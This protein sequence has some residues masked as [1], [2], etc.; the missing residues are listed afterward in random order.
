[1]KTA[2]RSGRSKGK[3][4]LTEAERIEIYERQKGVCASCGKEFAIEDMG[5]DHITPLSEGGSTSMDNCQMLC[6]ECNQKK[7]SGEGKVMVSFR[8]DSDIKEKVAV[9]AQ[10]HER[11]MSK[12]FARSLEDGLML[13]ELIERISDHLTEKIEM[14]GKVFVYEPD[15]KACIDFI[16]FATELVMEKEEREKAERG[17]KDE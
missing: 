9:A 4:T 11:T 13:Q 12:Q 5:I 15:E 16:I 10:K 14:N 3:A 8:L 2:K 6:L 1:M 7:G 17:K